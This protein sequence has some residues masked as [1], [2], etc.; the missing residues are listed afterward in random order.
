MAALSVGLVV[1]SCVSAF[2]QKNEVGLLLGV[3]LS[4]TQTSQP[5]S[6]SLEIKHGL[7]SQATYARRLWTEDRDGRG[8]LLMQRQRAHEDSTQALGSALH[9]GTRLG[10]APAPNA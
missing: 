4:N 9:P 10:R 6:A 1:L 3:T 5:L 8:N 7:T 2:A